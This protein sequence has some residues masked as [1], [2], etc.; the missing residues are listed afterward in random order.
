[1]ESEIVS[2]KALWTVERVDLMKA[3][4]VT[5]ISASI[6]ASR[7]NEQTGSTFTRNAIIGKIHREELERRGKNYNRAPKSKKVAKKRKN[8]APLKSTDP[9]MFGTYEPRVADV[10]PRHVSLLDL[11]AQECRFPYGDGPFTFCAHSAPEGHS[12]C[13]VHALLTKGI[14]THSERRSSQIPPSLEAVL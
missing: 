4:Y 13:R 1:M 9:I 6:M 12:Y 5:G 7:M 3:L 2:Q 10:I 8:K 14:G 11:Q